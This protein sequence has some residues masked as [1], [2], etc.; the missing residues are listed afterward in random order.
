[1]DGS[2]EKFQEEFKNNSIGAGQNIYK[3][4]G[5]KTREIK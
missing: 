1:M 4:P 3:I 5:Q 2:S